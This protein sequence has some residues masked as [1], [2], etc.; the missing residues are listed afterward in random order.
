MAV[1]EAETKGRLCALMSKGND[2]LNGYAEASDCFC[3][4]NPFKDYR[5]SGS[6]LEF[7]EKAVEAALEAREK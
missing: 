3:G 1:S 4:S 7:I 5:N 2:K 6:A